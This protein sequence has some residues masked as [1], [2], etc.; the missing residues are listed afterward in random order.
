MADDFGRTNP[1]PAVR[2]ALEIRP[3]RGSRVPC[4]ISKEFLVAGV[5]QMVLK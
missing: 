1:F 2:D 5:E 4:E 3:Q